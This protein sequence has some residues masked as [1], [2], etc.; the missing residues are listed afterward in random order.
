LLI[1]EIDPA[2][3]QPRARP[4]PGHHVCM[5]LDTS[6]SMARDGRLIVASISNEDDEL[7]VGSFSGDRVLR[8]TLEKE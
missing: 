5:V 1:V 4:G 2:E 3:S 8:V 6:G 7:F